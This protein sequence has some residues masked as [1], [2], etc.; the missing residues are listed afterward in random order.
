MNHK[1]QFTVILLLCMIIGGLHAQGGNSVIKLPQPQKS[2]EMSLE[3][4]LY[5][6]HSIRSYA[7]KPLTLEQLAQVLWAGKGVNVDGISGP[8]RTAPSAGGLYPQELFA[9]IGNV[10]GLEAG[11]YAYNSE[12]H[13]LELIR[14][15]DFRRQ[16]SRAAL[17]QDFIAK[18]PVA[19]VIGAV[20]E[21]STRKYG[22]RGEDRYVHMDAAHSAQ[23]I[24]LQATAS[25]LATVTIGA[26]S[27]KQVSKLMGLEETQP[28]YIMPVGYEKH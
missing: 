6:R 4:A 28:L 20:Y 8:T 3:E 14:E 10:D 17:M 22:K 2:G 21:R 16:L 23:N 11:V 27:D 19:V 12:Q 13:G 24:F 15:G 25:G 5:R 9:V 18:A 26:F 7:D 1:I